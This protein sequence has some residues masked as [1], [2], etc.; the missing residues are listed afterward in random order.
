MIGSIRFRSSCAASSF[1]RARAASAAPV[2]YRLHPLDLLLLERRVDAEDLDRLFVLLLV[3]I[4]TDDHPLAALDLRL[5]A[6]AC[7]GDLTL[8]EVLLDRR[9]RRGRPVRRNGP[10]GVASSFVSCSR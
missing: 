8:L 7:L 4:D 5:V 3:T 9:D 10:C 6:E 1:S 2:S